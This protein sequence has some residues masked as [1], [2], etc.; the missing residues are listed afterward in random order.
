MKF[1][2][3]FDDETV[4]KVKSALARQ[5]TAKVGI[6]GGGEQAMIGR[7]HEFGARIPVSDRM[8][9]WWFHNVGGNK[10][11]NPIVIP[12]RSFLRL[13][14]AMKQQEFRDTVAAS[15]RAIGNAKDFGR[16]LIERAAIAYTALVKEAFYSAGFGTWKP[17]H[18]VTQLL[19]GRSG[20]PLINSSELVRSITYQVEK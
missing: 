15:A 2:L 6:L 7:V 18:A 8:R 12:E 10:T 16:L 14:M 19:R 1:T 3:S 9:K 13:P 11:Y 4:A 17:I 20:V 5:Y